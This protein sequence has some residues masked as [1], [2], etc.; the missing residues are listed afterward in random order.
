MFET[1]FSIV[2]IVK[3]GFPASPSFSHW[4]ALYIRLA[5]TGYKPL[6]CLGIHAVLG[7]R[8]VKSVQIVCRQALGAAG[9]GLIGSWDM[10]AFVVFQVE[11]CVCWQGQT[12]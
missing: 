3:Q 11:H 4:R 8:L 6:A 9:L 12:A 10:A 7:K 1:S 2:L 5:D